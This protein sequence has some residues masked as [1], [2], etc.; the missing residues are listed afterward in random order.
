MSNESTELN[1]VRNKI[2]IIDDEIL[3]K[4]HARQQLV[5]RAALIKQSIGLEAYQPERFRQLL[6]RLQTK[7]IT[8]GMQPEYVEDIWSVIHKQSVGS[9]ENAKSANIPMVEAK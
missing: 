4:L 3:A 6:D 8:L 2:D 1:Q 9:Q 5:G 7:A